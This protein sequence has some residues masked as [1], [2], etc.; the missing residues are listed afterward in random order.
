MSILPCGREVGLYVNLLDQPDAN[1]AVGM[2]CPDTVSL[3]NL[4]DE[5][6]HP[7]VLSP[8]GCWHVLPHVQVGH[9]G[10]HGVC[11]LDYLHF[12]NDAI[13][14]LYAPCKLLATVRAQSPTSTLSLHFCRYEIC[15][16]Q[17]V[18]CAKCRYRFL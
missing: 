12:P 10:R 9:M 8:P 7:Y 15:P 6:L 3:L 1:V 16:K 2:G 17:N 14:R 5:A 13:H 4:P 18:W 11:Y